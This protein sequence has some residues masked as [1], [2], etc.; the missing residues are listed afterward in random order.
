MTQKESNTIESQLH[1]KEYKAAFQLIVKFF[2]PMLY[3]IIFKIVKNHTDTD[4]ILQNTFIKVWQ[5]LP[6]FNFKS[7]IYTW[8]YTIGKNES[9]GWLRKNKVSYIL[10]E[11]VNEPSY[12]SALGTEEIWTKLTSAVE[13]LPAKQKRVFEMKYFMDK[14]YDEISQEL[15]L[16]TG[17]LKANYHHA[18]QK[19]RK[20][21]QKNM[22]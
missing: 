11:V 14:T 3:A 17:G 9:L 6:K 16:T 15:N 7:Q 4:D 2:G 22:I 1:Q 18:V 20:E 19:I 5:N 12:L 13:L 8:C 21:L 10:D